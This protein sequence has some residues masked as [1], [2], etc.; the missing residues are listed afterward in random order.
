MAVGPTGLFDIRARLM[1]VYLHDGQFVQVWP[2][3]CLQSAR[4]TTGVFTKVWGSYPDLPTD[5]N[6]LQPQETA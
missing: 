6:Q 4:G 3:E 2:A 1:R 5:C